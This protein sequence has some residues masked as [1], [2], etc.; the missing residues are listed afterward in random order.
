MLLPRST[1]HEGTPGTVLVVSTTSL[2]QHPLVSTS[3]HHF[4]P[5]K[6]LGE[7]HLRM[8]SCIYRFTIAKWWGQD[9]VVMFSICTKWKTLTVKYKSQV[10]LLFNLSLRIKRP[11][12]TVLAT[13]FCELNQNHQFKPQKP[14]ESYRMSSVLTDTLCFRQQAGLKSF[15][16]YC[17]NQ[18]TWK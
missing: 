5:K 1:T 7:Q 18:M 4:H 13:G 15:L 11:V 8:Q 16:C 3:A 17:A 9:E 10:Y 2:V 12:L 14:L 6:M